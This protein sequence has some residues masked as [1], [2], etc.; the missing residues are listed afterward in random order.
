MCTRGVDVVLAYA[1]HL[2]KKSVVVKV[3]KQSLFDIIDKIYQDGKAD[4]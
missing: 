3:V 1:A 4:E 2:R